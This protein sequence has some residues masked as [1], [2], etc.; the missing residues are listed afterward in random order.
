MSGTGKYKLA[1]ALFFPK[2]AKWALKWMTNFG[3]GH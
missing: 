1:S 3:K 2:F